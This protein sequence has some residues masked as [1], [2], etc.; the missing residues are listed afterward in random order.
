MRIEEVDA[1]AVAI[2]RAVVEVRPL[3]G[4]FSHETCL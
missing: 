1:I 4:G 2:G 3:A